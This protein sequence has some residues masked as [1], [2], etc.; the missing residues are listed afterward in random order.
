MAQGWQRSETYLG[1]LSLI[2][3]IS[4]LPG[5]H[6]HTGRTQLILWTVGAPRTFSFIHLLNKY[7][8]IRRASQVAQW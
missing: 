5:L 1:D 6:T 4:S 2:T 3:A 7:V 8:A